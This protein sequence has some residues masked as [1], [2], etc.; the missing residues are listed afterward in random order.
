MNQIK[1]DGPKKLLSKIPT[2]IKFQP[3]NQLVV[4]GLKGSESKFICHFT[5]SIPFKQQLKVDFFTELSSKLLEKGTD[6]VVLIFYVEQEAENYREISKIFFENLSLKIHVKDSLWVKNDNWASYLCE[7]S[8]CC[9]KEGNSLE[10]HKTSKKLDKDFLQIKKINQK[11]NNQA[12]KALRSKMD[13]KDNIS[14]LK[15]QKNQFKQLSAKGAFT[16]ADKKNWARLLVGL[17][18]IPV[19]DA[20]MS[21]FIEVSLSKKDPSKYLIDLAKSCAK[22]ATTADSQ[23]QSP[24]FAFTSVFLWQAEQYEVAKIAVNLSLAADLKFRLA[25]LVQNALESGVPAQE[26]RDVFKNPSH[27]WA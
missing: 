12:K 10:I 17:T 1:I 19:R 8:K 16:G 15:W 25:H 5:Y 21:H 11:V 23:F 24:I 3:C 27:P 9:P 6:S 18:D 4:C 2:I 22:I 13:I 20:L 26:F 7:D 14:L